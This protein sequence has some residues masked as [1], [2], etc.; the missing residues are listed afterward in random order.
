MDGA[1][2]GGFGQTSPTTVPPKLPGN[3]KLVS[4]IW[5]DE[6]VL[7]YPSEGGGGGGRAGRFA[8]DPGLFH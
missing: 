8:S 2:M 5:G 4:C 7:I 6:S 3:S 1:L